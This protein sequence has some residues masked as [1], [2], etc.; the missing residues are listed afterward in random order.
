M[1]TNFDSEIMKI[2]KY[3]SSIISQMLLD[4][5]TANG[6]TS[7]GDYENATNLVK[8]VIESVYGTREDN[9]AELRMELLA[10]LYTYLRETEQYVV[11]NDLSN[12]N[13]YVAETLIGETEKVDNVKEKMKNNTYKKQNEFFQKR[14][15]I[16]YN[17]FV[18]N[19]IKYLILLSIFIIIMTSLYLKDYISNLIFYIIVCSSVIVSLLII[20]LYVKN[21]QTR[22]KDD[23]NKYYFSG[24]RVDETS[25]S[26]IAKTDPAQ[27][28]TTPGTTTQPPATPGTTSV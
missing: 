18:K 3:D 15:V 6:L 25:K 11:L 12:N 20:L 9:E 22:R 17:T 14:Y 10:N 8:S 27:S 7:T 24:M 26:C 28:I 13:K 2:N 16:E 4:F 21:T 23:W 19:I 1:E 5:N